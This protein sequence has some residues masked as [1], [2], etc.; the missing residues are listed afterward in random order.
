MAQQ[1]IHDEEDDIIDDDDWDDLPVEALTAL[2]DQAIQLT[3]QGHVV[4]SP[5][6]KKQPH[7]SNIL[8]TGRVS[9]LRKADFR[10]GYDQSR[11]HGLKGDKTSTRDVPGAKEPST[12]AHTV[13]DASKARDVVRRG[14]QDDGRN[15]QSLGHNISSTGT[16][17]HQA[18]HGK[19]PYRGRQPDT[20]SASSQILGND[21][22]TMSN[23]EAQI[24]KV[25]SSLD[26]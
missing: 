4:I 15:V 10:G 7:I 16:S 9:T 17:Q 3:Q 8:P 21:H 19:V 26:F 13:F 23:L 22:N 14:P 6:R 2:E 18:G 12:K 1:N 11:N 5:R 25:P 24:Q 20:N